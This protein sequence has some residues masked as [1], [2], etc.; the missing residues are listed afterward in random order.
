[1]CKTCSSIISRETN[2]LIGVV[3]NFIE[4]KLIDYSEKISIFTKEDFKGATSK[5]IIR[6]TFEL[7]E[8][9]IKANPKTKTKVI[10]EALTILNKL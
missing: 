9:E 5:N 1:M 6:I 2:R 3:E 8:A 7:T 10:K 4:G